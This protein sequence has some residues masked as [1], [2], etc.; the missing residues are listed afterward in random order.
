MFVTLKRR[1]R[2]QELDWLQELDRLRCL[3][4]VQQVYTAEIVYASCASCIVPIAI[5]VI[6][7]FEHGSMR[8]AAETVFLGGEV[9]DCTSYEPDY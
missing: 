4:R 8:C 5:E 7:L 3:D 6:D 1:V 2:L 9:A